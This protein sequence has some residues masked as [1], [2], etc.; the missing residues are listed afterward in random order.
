VLRAFLHEGAEAGIQ[1]PREWIC[2]LVAAI[3]DATGEQLAH[4][5]EI[6]LGAGALDVYHAPL[7][8]KKGRPGWQLTVLAP[9]AQSELLTRLIFQHTPTAGVRRRDVSRTILTR[10]H[11][12]VDTGLGR[13]RM[14]VFGTNDH[15]LRAE[16]EYE[17]CREI[18]RRVDRPLQEI[19]ERARA[20][21]RKHK[22]ET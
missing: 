14:K 17:D 15:E 7:V 18:A 22:G 16:P 5:A 8:M 9:S 13:V 19:Q 12:E 10:A 6:L 11:V 20:A 2:E 4:A 21:Y 3:D 1:S